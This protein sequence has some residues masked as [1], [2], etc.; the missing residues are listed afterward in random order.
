MNTQNSFF[1]YFFLCIGW[2]PNKIREK[3]NQRK[4]ATEDDVKN[5]IWRM[6]DTVYTCTPVKSMSYYWIV[7]ITVIMITSIIKRVAQIHVNFP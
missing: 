2:N 3:T 1:V 6:I 4:I 5:S 7:T